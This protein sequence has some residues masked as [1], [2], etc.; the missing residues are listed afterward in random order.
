MYALLGRTACSQ[1]RCGLLLQMSHVAWSLSLPVCVCV[2]VCVTVCWGHKLDEFHM[3]CLRRIASIKWQDRV[4]NTEVLHLCG[5][6]DIEAFL[7]QVQFRWVGHVVRMQDNRIPKQILYGQ[8]SFGKR[9]QCGPFRRYKDTVRDNLKMCGILPQSLVSAPLDRGQWRSTYRTAI[10]AFE[11][12]RVASVQRKWAARKH[13]IV[14]STNTA[15][16]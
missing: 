9:P 14:S 7:L 2:C 10:A 15:C 4:H 12:A 11:E 3:R 6:T 16:V 13:Q 1:Y 8:L 5:T